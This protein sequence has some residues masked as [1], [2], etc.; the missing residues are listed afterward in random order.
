MH[1]HTVKKQID[2]R[3]KSWEH[4]TELNWKSLN[5]HLSISVAQ[6]TRWDD[7]ALKWLLLC[8]RKKKT[9][10]LRKQCF[11]HSGTVIILGRISKT[12]TEKRLLAATCLFVGPSVVTEQIGS[13]RTDFREILYWEFCEK[14]CR[15]STCTS[16]Y[17]IFSN[18]TFCPHSAFVWTW[19]QT[20]IIFLHRINWLVCITVI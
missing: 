16:L 7:T 8:C 9:L 13:H 6:R 17:L 11:R 14:V 10:G 12:I 4:F 18:S 2:L 15:H 19:E 1:T 5:R 20:T 3:Y